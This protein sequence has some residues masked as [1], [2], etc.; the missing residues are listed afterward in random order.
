MSSTT[1]W[2][3]SFLNNTVLPPTNQRLN[4]SKPTGYAFSVATIDFKELPHESAFDISIFFFDPVTKAF[5]GNQY[6]SEV[7]KGTGTDNLH[8]HESTFFSGSQQPDKVV[9]VIELVKRERKALVYGFTVV[10]LLSKSYALT[11]FS[12]SNSRNFPWRRYQFF[13]GSCKILLNCDGPLEENPNLVKLNTFL[14]C[15]VQTHQ[16][17]NDHLQFL[18]DYYIVGPKQKIPGF[19]SAS[20]GLQLANPQILEMYTAVLDNVEILY[21]AAHIE[22]QILELLNKERCFNMNKSPSDATVKPLSVTDRRCRIGVHNSITFVEEPLKF[23]LSS[24]HGALTGRQPKGCRNASHVSSYYLN[25][26]VK[27]S[28][29]F[30]D[31]KCALIFM[32]EYQVGVRR[33]NN[34]ST[35]TQWLLICWNAWCP[36]SNGAFKQAD[37]ITLPLVGGARP[38]PLDVLCFKHLSKLK[39]DNVLGAEN[40]Q[41]RIR[42]NYGM[43]GDSSHFSPLP[44]RLSTP[45]P[46]PRRLKQETVVIQDSEDELPLKS[47]ERRSTST[48]ATSKTSPMISRKQAEKVVEAEVEYEGRAESPEVILKPASV[49]RRKDVL[50]EAEDFSEYTIASPGSPRTSLMSRGARAYFTK[51]SIPQILDRHGKALRHVDIGNLPD[52]NL[53]LEYNTRLDT[54]E[55]VLQFIG[56]TLVT[57]DVY[58][59]PTGNLKCFFTFQF[60]RFNQIGTEMLSAIPGI[61]FKKGDPLILK[62]IDENGA[63]IGDTDGLMMRFVI[64]RYST[65]NSHDFA[66]F[67]AKGN[68]FIDVWDAESLM[69]MGTCTV[70]LKALLRN[71]TDG[72]QAD[73]QASAI[74]SGFP[75]SEP[76]VTSVLFL[77][78]A[79]VGHPTLNQFDILNSHNKSVVSSFRLP[80]LTMSTSDSRFKAKPLE[81]I[82]ESALQRLFVAQKIDIKQREQDIFGDQNLYLLENWEKLKQK[83]ELKSNVKMK[84][85]IFKE[86]LEAYKRLRSENKA[87]KL[88]KTIFDAITHRKTVFLKKG[89]VHFFEF[90]LKNTF[91]QHIDVVIDL[92]SSKL[93]VVTNHDELK[94]VEQR[95]GMKFEKDLVKGIDGEYHL[96]LK[97]METLAIPFKVDCFELNE[98]ENNQAFEVKAIFKSSENGEPISILE[99]NCHKFNTITSQSFRWFLEEN[100]KFARVVRLSTQTR[101]Q[102]LRCTDPNVLCLLR[103]NPTSGQEIVLSGFSSDSPFCL[104]F[105][106]YLFKDVFHSE[107]ALTLSI[108]AHSLK[109][110]NVQTIQGQASRIPMCFGND[111]ELTNTMVKLFSSSK[112]LTIQPTDNIFIDE[113][114]AKNMKAVVRPN[115]QE[116]KAIIVTAV[117]ANL[118]KLLTGW[119][120]YVFV[121]KPN[122]VKTFRV[123]IPLNARERISK[124]IPVDNRY[125]STKTFRVCSS[126][127]KILTIE[128]DT[129]EIEGDS[130]KNINVFFNPAASNRPFT[131]NEL[132][133]VENAQNGSQEEAYSLEIIYQ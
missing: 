2:Y 30:E 44:S 64:D 109:R 10:P 63:S 128:Q 5:F 33:A 60:Y 125:P 120:F 113:M 36:Y 48:S 93:Q 107:L 24:G 34:I 124:R 76:T 69:H 91:A 123:E 101:I 72:V 25:N 9:L 89:E 67:L 56:V 49:S 104:E 68:L 92:N 114:I 73:I 18:P 96:Y 8:F 75:L 6:I 65:I 132:F 111:I 66:N 131:V 54:H 127:D 118:R 46:V 41:I 39:K 45:K 52:H 47:L 122:I 37:T 95:L 83:T 7:K 42:F 38:N 11:D 14:N 110:L 61:D 99:L 94:Y 62:R 43:V 116:R 81:S 15:V 84:K 22:E 82:H 23:D 108:T 103:N 51:T 105:Q 86:E 31:D 17:L 3:N 4:L 98:M 1:A 58:K 35:D 57:N 77:R 26:T 55:I 121:T 21:T 13:K 117:D 32:F 106:I 12:A 112:C 87:M 28:K 71:G 126:N 78:M 19:V 130:S 129:I 74:Q 53:N 40:A 20:E 102:S 27:L 88:L 97:S 16:Q 90:R 59:H 115:F 80:R 79:N 50:L 70:P 119:L 85:F 133:Y 29:L 100:Q